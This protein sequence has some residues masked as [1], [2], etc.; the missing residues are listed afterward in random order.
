M[1]SVCGNHGN[2]RSENKIK[3]ELGKENPRKID[4][5]GLYT[6]PVSEGVFEIIARS[7]S[8]EDLKGSAYVVVSVSE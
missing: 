7:A 4:A 2:S 5:N 6:A 3:W 1:N 8:F